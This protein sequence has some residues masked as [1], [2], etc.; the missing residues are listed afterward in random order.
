MIITSKQEAGLWLL[1]DS[2]GRAS[3]EIVVMFNKKGSYGIIENVFVEEKYRN[4]GIASLLVEE[5]KHL[6]VEKQFYKLVLTCSNE[7]MSFYKKLDFKWQEDGQAYC[8]RL[9]LNE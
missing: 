2:E 7:L 1:K 5:A 4:K 3:L 6:A 9:D 8:M